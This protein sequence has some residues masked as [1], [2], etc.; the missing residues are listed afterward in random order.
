MC[1]SGVHRGGELGCPWKFFGSGSGSNSG[2]CIGGGIGGKIGDGVGVC[3]GCSNLRFRRFISLRLVEIESFR[4]VGDDLRG[5][6]RGAKLVEG[7]GR[8]STFRSI[9]SLVDKPNRKLTVKPSRRPT[10]APNCELSREP[11]REPSHKPSGA[12]GDGGVV[13]VSAHFAGTGQ[14]PMMEDPIAVLLADPVVVG[15]AAAKRESG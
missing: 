8:K 9:R 11:G 3:S 7:F 13:M 6:N 5:D 15:P 1:K 10:R 4:T 14:I 2:N 12:V